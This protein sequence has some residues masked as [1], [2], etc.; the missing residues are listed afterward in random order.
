[1]KIKFLRKRRGAAVC[2]ES[3]NVK[4]NTISVEL[5]DERVRWTRFSLPEEIAHRSIF[6]HF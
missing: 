3:L 4:P 5:K 1:M 2:N 6:L